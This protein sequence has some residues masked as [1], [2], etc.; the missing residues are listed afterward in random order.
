M[1]TLQ[2]NGRSLALVLLG[3]GCLDAP[4]PEV[5]RAEYEK[6]ASDVETLRGELEACQATAESV[7]AEERLTD[8]EEATIALITDDTIY[9]VGPTGDYADLPEALSALD[10]Y[11][12]ASGA[13]VTFQLEAGT[14]IFTEALEIQHPDGE[15]IAILGDLA[16]PATTLLTFDGTDGVR[17]IQNH[18]LGRLD[19]VTLV[20]LQ[21]GLGSGVAAETGSSVIVGDRSTVNVV[22]RGWYVGLA[23]TVGA[24]IIADGG[25]E[26][27]DCNVGIEAGYNS[28]V[29][30]QAADVRSSETAAMAIHGSVLLA[31]GAE[32]EG[33]VTGV[34]SAYGSTAYVQSSQ[35]SSDDRAL[36]TEATSVV[37]ADGT[38]VEDG[39]IYVAWNTMLYMS[40]CSLA[41]ANFWVRGDSFAYVDG[42][43]DFGSNVVEDDGS[44]LV[45]P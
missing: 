32:L 40:T 15:R 1:R 16:D 37:V 28:V 13:S 26:V 27:E 7:N 25:V 21:S 36:V 8:L 42:C 3:T 38:A 17:V 39:D 11:R 45:G 30:A 35:V 5:T 43:T 44:L 6:L 22:L 34:Y 10:R 14:H 18:A 9:T 41:G 2:L 24:S 20:Q 4:E 23:A 31:T 12:I 33:S 29:Q 19:G